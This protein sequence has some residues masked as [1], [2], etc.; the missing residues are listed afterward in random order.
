M[1]NSCLAAKTLFDGLQIPY[2]IPEKNDKRTLQRGS[3]LSPEEICL[4]F[5]IMMGNY[6][7]SIER[8][9]D[10]ILITGSCGPCRFGE[11]CEL[12]MKI[13]KR[14]G[15]NI[16]IIVID[17]P[18]DIGRD[19]FWSR[20]KKISQES[21]PNRTVKLNALR[22]ALKVLSLADKIDAKAHFLAGYEAEKGECK[23]LLKCCETRVIN[24]D[25]PARV[26]KM[27]EFY[28]K[29]LDKIEVEK[30]K[31]PLKVALIGEIY[32]MIEPFSNLYIEEKLMDYGVSTT[33][34]ITPSWWMKDLLLK[35][36]KLNSLN[37]RRAANKFLPVGV[38]GHARE[39]VA[40]AVLSKEKGVDGVLQIYPLGCMPEIIAKS[41]L[42]IIQRDKDMPVMS[43]VI[44][45]MTGET[46]YVTRI[47]AYLDMLMAKKK[48]G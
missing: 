42:P 37:V 30:T 9:A 35:P 15:L 31:N 7:E 28:D 36:L 3:Y 26:Q 33:R 38:G 32:S 45:E 44:D 11:Y 34:L 23:R 39:S 2:V 13:L 12:Q 46:G 14:Q 8:G 4:P 5:K 18:S 19:A 29:K 17:S 24:C 6:I 20:I 47:E 16:D 22:R 40:H 1:G 10:T 41:I 25:E 21:R 48:K 43:L 27:L